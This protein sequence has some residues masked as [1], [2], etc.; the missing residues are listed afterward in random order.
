MWEWQLHTLWKILITELYCRFKQG[1]TFWTSSMR[2]F[3]SL[4]LH[5]YAK[6]WLKVDHNKFIL[7]TF[8]F[9]CCRNEGPSCLTVILWCWFWAWETRNGSSTK[10]GQG[11]FWIFLFLAAIYVVFYFL[12]GLIE[13]SGG[14]APVLLEGAVFNSWNLLQEGLDILH[15]L[16][17]RCYFLRFWGCSSW[18]IFSSSIVSINW[19]MLR[20]R[21]R[22]YIRR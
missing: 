11:Q 6:S 7:V 21:W 20:I 22:C 14:C 12:Q 2:S 8:C 1:M 4:T 16:K 5:N 3:P 19:R 15:Y 18:F 17:C 9:S 13:E 10:S